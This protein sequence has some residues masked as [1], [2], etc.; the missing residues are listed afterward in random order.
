MSKEP[1]EEHIS[2]DVTVL[3]EEP[4]SREGRTCNTCD[5][6]AF[7]V[8]CCIDGK[9]YDIFEDKSFCTTLSKSRKSW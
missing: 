3:Y 9:E 2:Q 4:L 1:T 7:G 8:L 5:Y 6:L